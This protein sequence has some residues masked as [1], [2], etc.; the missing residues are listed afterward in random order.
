MDS[1]WGLISE[2]RRRG[3]VAADHDF[4]ISRQP[5]SQRFATNC[6]DIFSMCKK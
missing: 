6:L 3:V 4:L 1:L 5:G 2:L